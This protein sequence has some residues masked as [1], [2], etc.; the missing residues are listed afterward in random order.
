VDEETGSWPVT[1]TSSELLASNQLAFNRLAFNRLAFNRLAF[2]RL[3]FNRLAFNRLAFNSLDHLEQSPD[4][5]DLLLYVAR[6]ALNDGDVLVATHGNQTYEFPGLLGLAP[7]WEYRALTAPEAR[8]V[9]ACLIAHVNAFGVPVEISLRA[10]GRIQATAQE[11]YD[12]PVYEAT[13]FGHVFGEAL[14]TYACLGHNAAIAAAHAP[15]RALRVCADP[16]P[17]EI[18]EVGYCRDVC[19]TYVTG[20]GWTGCQAG[21][22]RYDETVSVFLRSQG[23]ICRDICSGNGLLCNLLCPA[24]ASPPDPNDDSYAGPRI[25]DCNRQP[26]LCTASCRGGAC[27]V[28]ASETEMAF[29][30]FEAASTAELQCANTDECVVTCKGAGTR[31]D[32]D[33]TGAG[34]CSIER[35]A[36][37]ASCLLDCTGTDACDIKECPGVLRHCA[38]DVVACD[39]SCPEN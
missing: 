14:E 24:T 5:R 2:N 25:L 16:G 10:P 1:S 28:E 27:L 11:A 13:F 30:T 36:P 3:A 33:C 15:D 29:V 21:G 17:C 8:W 6:C 9:S 38:G 31:C 19:A 32:V 22:V 18:E 20:T 4:G 37:G 34:A 23:G 12:F 39:R 7:E 26:G 35:C